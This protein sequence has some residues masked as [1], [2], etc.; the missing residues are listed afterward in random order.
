V[1]SE[2]FQYQKFVRPLHWEAQPEV[3]QWYP[4][5][6]DYIDPEEGIHP[7]ELGWFTAGVLFS[8]VRESQEPVELVFVYGAVPTRESQEPVEVLHQY[9]IGI[10][11]VRAS[12]IPVEIIY[13]FGCFTFQPPPP[14]GCP[15]PEPDPAPTDPACP[16][17]PFNTLG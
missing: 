6:P 2:L 11:R 14:G 10:R 4:I 15:V 7:A 5:Y 17:P 16:T 8:T 9:A 12:Q 13:P 3:Q 1:E